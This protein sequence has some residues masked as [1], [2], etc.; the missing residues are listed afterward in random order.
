M[1]ALRTFLAAL[2]ATVA[3]LAAAAQAPAL[4]TFPVGPTTV[5]ASALAGNLNTIWE[6]VWG[7]DDFIWMTER[8]GRISRVNPA[9]GQVLPLLTIADVTENNESGLLGMAITVSPQVPSFPVYW[10]FVVYKIGRAHV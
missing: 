6:L 7:P 4:T 8:A 1:K 2:L 10:V 9:T 5:T 3:P